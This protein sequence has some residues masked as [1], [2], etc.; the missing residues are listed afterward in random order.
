MTSIVNAFEEVIT[1]QNVFAKYVQRKKN[2]PLF[3]VVMEKHM[4]PNVN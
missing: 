3:V 1:K 2:T 4:Q